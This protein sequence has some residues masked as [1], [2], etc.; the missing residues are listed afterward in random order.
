MGENSQCCQ[1]G[2]IL[3]TS[4]TVTVM[5]AF[6]RERQT[7]IAERLREGLSQFVPWPELTAAEP[8]VPRT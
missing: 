4:L 7:D 5:S 8:V 6:E 3:S 1:E 2:L